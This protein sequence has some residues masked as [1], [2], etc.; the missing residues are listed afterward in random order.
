MGVKGD[1]GVAGAPGQPGL[2]GLP[3]EKGV[4]GFPG[5][6]G[7]PGLPGDVTQIL[8]KDLFMMLRSSSL[9]SSVHLDSSCP[10]VCN[11]ILESLKNN[12]F[13]QKCDYP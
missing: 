7:A 12:E 9:S 10:K 4:Q 2:D 11:N 8:G 5:L 13:I 1:Q 6:D 3:G